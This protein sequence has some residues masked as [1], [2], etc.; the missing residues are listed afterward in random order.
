MFTHRLLLCIL[1][2]LF[3]L[4]LLDLL[5]DLGF[6]FGDQLPQRFAVVHRG[7]EGVLRTETDRV[8]M[9]CKGC[10]GMGGASEHATPVCLE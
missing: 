7:H 1:F 5:G 6:G 9:K 10:W 4:V 2:L 8:S 3:L